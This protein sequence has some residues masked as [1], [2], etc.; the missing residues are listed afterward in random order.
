MLGP[1]LSSTHLANAR[2]A[3]HLDHA[4]RIHRVQQ[5]RAS[6]ASPV[7]TLAQRV[8]TMKRLTGERLAGFVHSTASRG[9]SSTVAR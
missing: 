3:E 7:S 9:S 6:G 4:Q 2:H 5:E 8:L 1:S